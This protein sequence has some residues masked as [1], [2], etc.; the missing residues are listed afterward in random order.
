MSKITKFMKADY[1]ERASGRQAGCPEIARL[2]DYAR[3]ALDPK[4]RGAVEEHISECY[5]CLDAIVSIHDGALYKGPKKGGSRLKK[6]NMFLMLAIVCFLASFVFSRYFFQFLT[7]TA[8]LGV[9]WVVEGKTNKL[10]I[11][12]HDAWRKGGDREAGKAISEIEER[13]RIKF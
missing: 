13:G 7:A 1:R 8:I 11:T 12:I 3:G 5:G 10:L 4:A 6:E 2:C 9:K